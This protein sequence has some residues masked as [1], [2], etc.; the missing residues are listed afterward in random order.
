MPNAYHNHQ[1]KGHRDAMTNS[2]YTTAAEARAGSKT[3]ERAANLSA[4]NRNSSRQKAAN[5]RA[6]GL[7]GWND[8]YGG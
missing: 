3:A 4:Q 6:R 5:A 8:G 7:G 1:I 2:G